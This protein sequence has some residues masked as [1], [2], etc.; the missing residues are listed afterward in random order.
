M[1]AIVPM[2]KTDMQKKIDLYQYYNSKHS[3]YAKK[4]KESSIL[5]SKWYYERKLFFY[6]NKLNKLCKSVPTYYNRCLFGN[7]ESYIIH[8]L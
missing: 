7:Y 6:D 2:P 3:Y 4:L 5:L 1:R 8:G